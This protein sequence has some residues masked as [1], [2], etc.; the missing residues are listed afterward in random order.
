MTSS[1]A[2]FRP[3][4]ASFPF[5]HCIRVTQSWQ[6]PVQETQKEATISRYVEVEAHGGQADNVRPF[7]MKCPVQ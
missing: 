1:M 2:A 6:V 5:T 7:N 4:H 3:F